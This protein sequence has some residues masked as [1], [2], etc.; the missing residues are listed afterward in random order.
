MLADDG[1]G[2]LREARQ[3]L[4][5]AEQA[6]LSV[7]SSYH[8]DEGFFLL[9]S[10]LEEGGHASEVALNLANTY[11]KKYLDVLE[12]LLAPKD[13]PEPTLQRV[14]KLLQTMEATTF[15]ASYSVESLRVAVARRLVDSYYE[16]Y[17]EEE[18]SREIKRLMDQ[19]ARH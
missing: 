8:M 13:V 10:I 2:D 11:F 18:K 17:S 6:L 19:I 4:A 5:A 9:D 3:H 14:L 12:G 15:A 1:A 16:G 7:D